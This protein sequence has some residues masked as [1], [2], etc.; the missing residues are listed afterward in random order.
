MAVPPH[1]S[2]WRVPPTDNVQKFLLA[3]CLFDLIFF[4]YYLFHY[5]IDKQNTISDTLMS[6]PQYA[7]ILTILLATRALGGVLFLVRFRNQYPSWEIAGFCG[8]F[9]ALG[10]W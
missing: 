3:L 2:C 9:T 5:E 7:I 6:V 4:C 1:R 8:I 10:G